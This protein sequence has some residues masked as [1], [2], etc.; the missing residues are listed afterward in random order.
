[1]RLALDCYVEEVPD[2]GLEHFVERWASAG[3]ERLRPTL[4]YHPVRI[5]SPANPR[6]RLLDLEGDR[7]FLDQG[8]SD[9]FDGPV[10]P[11]FSER[12]AGVLEQLVDA[13]RA[14]GLAVDGWTVVLEQPRSGRPAP[15]RRDPD[16]ARLSRLH[17]ALAVASGEPRLRR[18]AHAG[19]RAIRVLRGA[20]DRGAL[21][22]DLLVPPAGGR[23]RHRPRRR[24]TAG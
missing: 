2:Y 9:S 4:A 17:V 10:V 3:V 20:P 1:M 21:P 5:F 16:R 13:C 15:G 19:G 6:R 8:A 24:S 14:R 23:A 7:C 18:R 22:P 11:I 12:S